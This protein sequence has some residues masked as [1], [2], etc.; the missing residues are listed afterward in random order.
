MS[1]AIP[2]I[3]VTR[4][5]GAYGRGRC[6]VAYTIIGVP[7]GLAWP[8]SDDVVVWECGPHMCLGGQRA[9]YRCPCGRP[10]GP[11]QYTP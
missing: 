10:V 6:D 5:R 2:A 9:Q 3:T 7:R 1:Y 11:G 4:V 8:V